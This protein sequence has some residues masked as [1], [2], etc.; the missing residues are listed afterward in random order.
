MLQNNPFLTEGYLSPEYFCDRVEET[1]LLTRHL[2][3]GCN[4]ALIAPRRMGKSGLI[5]NCFNEEEIRNNY[6]CIYIDIYET[7]NLNEFVYVMGKGILLELKSQGR[8]VWESFLNIMQSLKSTITFD[9]NGNPEWN[10]GLG[11]IASPDIT[12]DEIFEYL[13]HADKPCIVAIDEFQTIAGYPEKTVEAALRKRIQNCHNAKFVFSG[14]KRHMMALMFASESRPF[15]NS[16]SIM[17]LEPIN[18][19]AYFDFANHHLSKTNRS[20]SHEAFDWIYQSFDGITWYIQYILNMLYTHAISESAITTEDAKSVMTAIL[21]HHRFV[22]ESLLFQLSPKQK[23]VLLA[24]ANEGNATGVTSQAFLQKYKL[25]S[26][27]V[28]GAIKVLT[29]R[30]FI[31]YDN[32]SYQVSDRFFREWILKRF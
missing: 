2:T 7:K 29:E 25:G 10:V 28:Q 32:D 24:I 30:D 23:Q 11:D 4:V 17:G 18:K 8:K 14:S 26:S 12:L 3:N 5:Y 6:H 21:S 19:E 16:S 9:I 22:Y 1:A 27:T 20:I 31:S 15:Y 13:N